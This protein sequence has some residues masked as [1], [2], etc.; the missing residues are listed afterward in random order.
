[1]ITRA[2]NTPDTIVGMRVRSPTDCDG[3]VMRGIGDNFIT[4]YFYRDGY[5]YD[6]FSIGPGYW[7]AEDSE[8][9]IREIRRVAGCLGYYDK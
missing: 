4:G 1:M 7:R 2:D 6:H 3:Y 9:D 5:F 8:S